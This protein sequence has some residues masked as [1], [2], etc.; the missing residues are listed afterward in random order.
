MDIAFVDSSHAYE[1]GL[2][3]GLLAKWAAAS[4]ERAT[5]SPP[6]DKQGD[7]INRITVTTGSHVFEIAVIPAVEG[8]ADE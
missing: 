2:M 7:Y 3:V 5:N 4:G 6:T 1:T 8:D